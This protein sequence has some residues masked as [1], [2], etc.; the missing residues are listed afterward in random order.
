MLAK[1]LGGIQQVFIDYAICFTKLNIKLLNI[2]HPKAK[3]LDEVKRRKLDYSFLK[4]SN[5]YDLFARF[6]LFKILKSEN[7][8]YI[9]LHGNRAMQL[10]NLMQ[11]IFPNTK[12]IAICHNTWFKNA[13]NY[14]YYI[15]V[16]KYIENHL[17]HGMQKFCIPNAIELDAEIA[18]KT[19]NPDFITIGALGRV[20]DDKGFHILIKALAIAKET[21]PNI[22]L[23]IAGDGEMMSELKQ[24]TSS[25][26]LIGN[27]KFLGWIK[28]K[29]AF[30]S[31]IDIFCMPSLIEPFGIVALEGAKFDTPLIVSD[32]E[33]PVAIFTHN[34]NC[35]M[36]KK[37]DE[38][39]L[40]K[41]IVILAQD[42]ELRQKLSQNA[43]ALLIKKYSLEK[44]Q[45]NLS[46]ML[47]RLNK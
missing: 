16:S 4:N 26:N 15:M 31:K 17:P 5:K 40:A 28:D 23:Q 35:L 30:F 36:V 18:P 19:T 13:P 38:Q 47:E 20:V 7:P 37:S 27:V 33:G 46:K 42:A 41:Q 32:A 3:I 34:E 11:K 2:L 21:V 24:M 6:K 12:F 39:D 10:A 14:Q 29:S 22:K 1:D 8:D 45:V 9:L 25:L 44:M 43:K